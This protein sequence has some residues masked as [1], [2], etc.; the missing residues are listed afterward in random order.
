MKSGIT[1]KVTLL[2]VLFAVLI[3]VI[4]GGISVY[5]SGQSMTNEAEEALVDATKLGSE[6]INIIV[7]D[8]LLVL[9]EIANRS[10]TQ[11]MNFT[12]QQETLKGDVERLG[13]LDMAIVTPTGQ[14][15]YVTSGDTTDLSDRT[16]IQKALAGEMNVSDVLI[17]KVTNS[18]V[19]MY[20]VPITKNGRVIGALIGRRDGNALSEITD[21]MGFGDEGYAYVIN[22]K[23]ITVAHENRE[24]V[25]TQFQPIEA[26]K[27][28]ETLKPVATAFEDILKNKNGVGS[29][30]YKG[31]DLYYAYHPIEGTNWTLVNTAFKSE[32]LGGVKSLFISLLSII[33]V[34]VILASVVAFFLARSIATPIV[35]L[36]QIVNRQ[37]AL[38]FTKDESMDFSK[39]E[40]RKDEIGSMTTALFS[41]SENVRELLINV[42]STAEQVSATSEEL[43]ATSHQSATASEEVA[44][45]V[46]EIA[47]GASD[48]AKNTMDA[49]T[50][51]N[52]LSIEIENNQ[53]GTQDLANA[54]AEIT[55]LVSVGLT[56]VSDLAN[57]THENAVASDVVYSSIQKTN[58]SSAKISEASSMITSISEQ[59]NLLALNASI[60]A[61][62]A[63]EHGR[64][65]AVVA[66]EIRKLAEQSR[67]TTTTI[68][69]M[70]SRLQKDAETAVQ[71]MQESG[72]IVKE[73]EKC[74]ALTKDTFDQIA[75]AIGHSEKLV[76]LINQTSMKMEENK[77]LVMGNIDTLSAVAEENAASTE[78]ASAAIEEQTASAEQIAEAS[79]DLSEMAQSLQT[80]IRKFKV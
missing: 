76:N 22:D 17:S 69:E 78:Q 19:L 21:E 43:T 1:R 25:M 46:N 60:E 26:V 65:F 48:Q 49:A 6:K 14:A 70:V 58:E 40:K 29:Y 72:V 68:D 27:T 39:I 18:A 66:D 80:M 59:T 31:N 4:V 37:A 42:S 77:T 55:R 36:T 61:A 79:E 50:A 67:L 3:C 32:V 52:H 54:S 34:V 35:A 7:N 41:M 30:T 12:I 71:K 8:R 73:E 47:K 11:S 15:T 2:I 56:V 38:D 75:G 44:Q 62:R 57:K 16:Y 9:K 28:D 10:D 64:G 5:I 23:G 20:A 24:F 45:T 63:G 74:V 33:A 53:K 13:Y 51:L